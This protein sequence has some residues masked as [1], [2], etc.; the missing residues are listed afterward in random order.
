MVPYNRNPMKSNNIITFISI[1]LIV[2]ML[3]S[4]CK[5]MCIKATI[6]AYAFSVQYLKA[7]P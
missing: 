1:G 2:F 5:G 3:Y 7:Q 4:L 6:V